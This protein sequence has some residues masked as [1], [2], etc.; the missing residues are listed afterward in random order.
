MVCRS[1]N[2]KMLT[3][4]DSTSLEF[5]NRLREPAAQAPWT[6]VSCVAPAGEAVASHA[7]LCGFTRFE[8]SG[9]PERKPY[10]ISRI[11][12]YAYWDFSLEYS[13]IL[14]FTS[15]K[16]LSTVHLILT[17]NGRPI[18]DS[19]LKIILLLKANKRFF[20]EW[21]KINVC[22]EINSIEN[23]NWSCR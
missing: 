20:I 12:E 5:V 11:L 1:D 4:A 6:L 2:V 19:I 10:D 22:F 13:R 17:Y 18:R 21:A 16:K 7:K 9:T 15:A 3:S 8:M 14:I 23:V